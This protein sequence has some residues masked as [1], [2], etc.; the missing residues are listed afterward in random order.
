[1][2]TT[3]SPALFILVFKTSIRFDI[4]MPHIKMVLSTISGIARWN[5]D[6]HDA[7]NI[8]RIESAANVSREVIAALNHNGYYCAELED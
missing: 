7:D 6:R 8:L 5:F 1:M 3:I 4:D 2:S